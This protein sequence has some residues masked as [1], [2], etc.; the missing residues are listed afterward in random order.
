MHTW[1]P[2]VCIFHGNCDDGFAS[3]WA[4]WRRWGYDVTYVAGVYGKPLQ[5]ADHQIAGAN[6]LFVDYSLPRDGLEWLLGAHF[7]LPGAR[8]IVILDH[9]KTAQAALE[10]F[11]FAPKAGTTVSPEDVP[12]M[13]LK[14]HEIDRPPIV[15]LFDMQQSGARMTWEFCHGIEHNGAPPEIVSLIEDRDL[16]RFAYGD[17]TR[18]F[19]AALRTYPM[20][21]EEWAKIA[22]DPGRLIAEAPAIL[23][24]HNA[25]IKKFMADAFEEEIGGYKVPCCNVPYHYASDTAHALLEDNPTAHFAAAWFKRGDGQFQYSLRST[26]ERVDV[27][28]I[29]KKYGGGGHRNAAGFQLGCHLSS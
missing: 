21:F 20:N 5:L 6:I 16:W 27:S 7:D 23:R 12:G 1:K 29:A 11:V 3:A 19:S 26:D 14:L 9:H 28:E 18:L 22:A 24:A 8:S 17:R 10:P 15:A 25:N 2:D 4:V 13:L